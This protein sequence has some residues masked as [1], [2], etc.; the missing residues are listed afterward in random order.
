[1]TGASRHPLQPLLRG[2]VFHKINKLCA[3]LEVLDLKETFFE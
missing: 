2:R 1:M 3:R